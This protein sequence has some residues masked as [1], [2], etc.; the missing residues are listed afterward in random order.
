MPIR[1]Q[2]RAIILGAGLQGVCASLAL[3][4]E[5]FSVALIDKSSDCLLRASLRNEGKIHLGFVY[6]NDKTFRTSALM[7]QAA[8][9]FAP[10]VE[11]WVGRKIDWRTLRSRPF[12]YGVTADSMLDADEVREAFSRLQRAFANYRDDHPVNY[13]GESPRTLFSVAPMTDL[14]EGIDR[15]YVPALIN[16]CEVALDLGAF[17]SILKAAL[18]ERTVIEQRY[19]RTVEI[20]SRT[21][22]G[23]LVEG[24]DRLGQAWRQ[25]GDIVVNCL[26]EGRLQIDHTMGIAPDRKWVYRLKY[27]LLGDTPQM[28]TAL[29]SLTLVIGPYGD[30]VVY[31]EGRTY[32]SWYP[33]CM[34]GWCEELT[35]PES[36]EPPC[37]GRV[38]AP[39]AS[40]IAT[41]AC[42]AF[43]QIVPGLQQFQPDIV[44]AGV[45]FSWGHTDIDDPGSG[46]HRRSEI[47]VNAADGYFSIN[48]G[49]LTTAPLFADDLIRL[50]RG[51]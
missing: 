28:L 44:D 8:L 50:I 1:S 46:L 32:L 23:F 7:L 47:G 36:W 30:L 33:E 43:S 2:S 29:P 39:L 24:I 11:R 41:Q 17:R 12:A 5:G 35:I 25:Q 27:R 42:D 40:A 9:Q 38:A 3:A 19:D 31:P 4:Q 45:I 26:W 51:T 34:Q 37:D 20:V 49:K 13:L 10:L 14:R 48:T 16:T 21:P 15:Q 6:A 18:D 22:N